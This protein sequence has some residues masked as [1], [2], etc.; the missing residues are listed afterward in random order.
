YG[1]AFFE[2]LWRGAGVQAVAFALVGLAVFR[3]QPFM[4][5]P[6]RGLAILNLTWWAASVRTTL[7]DAGLDGWGAAATAASSALA[8]IF[9]VLVAL[10]PPAAPAP[11]ARRAAV[12]SC[13]H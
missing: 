11:G 7:A 8:G 5:A 1:A 9:F 3:I 10:A 4:A 12:V 13:A 2:H 6:T